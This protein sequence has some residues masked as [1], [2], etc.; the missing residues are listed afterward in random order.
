MHNITLV[1]SPN[2]NTTR[3]D[4]FKVS[5]GFNDKAKINAVLAN[6]TLKYSQSNSVSSAA[7][8]QVLGVGAGQQS[9]VDCVN[10]GKLL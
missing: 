10:L 4:D 1:Q 5:V 7:G 9:R 8:G 3:V 2:L 6:T